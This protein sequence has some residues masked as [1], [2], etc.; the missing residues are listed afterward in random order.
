MSH[1]SNNQLD[2][3]IN[4]KFQTSLM[5]DSKWEKLI[6]RITDELE[7]VFV[8]YKLIHSNEIHQTSFDSSDF[9]PFFIEPI[10]YKEVE[11]V[12]FPAEYEAYAN[13]D[14]LKAG[15]K[16]YNQNL[17][18]LEKTLS[19]IGKYEIEKNNEGIKIYAYK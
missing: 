17:L 10:L 3:I 11:W 5:S 15:K 1:L 7:E 4:E 18:L 9:K 14:N 8:K 19:S 6:N 16:H 2:Q 13:P 12:E